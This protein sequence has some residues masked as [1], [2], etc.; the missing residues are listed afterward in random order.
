MKLNH[1]KSWFCWYAT[2]SPCLKKLGVHELSR[3]I[4]LTTTIIL[5]L[6][7]CQANGNAANRLMYE[8]FDDQVLD[9]RFNIIGHDWAILNPPQYNMN[10]VG[11]SGSGYCFTSGTINEAYLHWRNQIPNPWPTDEFYVSFW[12]RYPTFRTTDSHENLKLFYPHWDGAESYVH[13]AMSNTNSIY[14]SA[15]AKGTMVTAGRWLNCPN[16]AD[17]KWHHYEF[18]VKFSTGV[19]KFWYDGALIVNDAYGSGRW[20]PTMR[21]ISAPSIDAEEP[22]SFSRQVDDWEVWD[23]MPSGG[24]PTPGPPTPS[25]PPTDTTAPSYSGFSP[26]SGATAVPVSTNIT[27]HVKDSGSGVDKS[28]IAM[29]VNGSKVTPIITGTP[30]DYILFFNPPVNFGYGTK[31]LVTLSAKDMSGNSTGIQNFSFTTSTSNL[32]A[33]VPPSPAGVFIRIM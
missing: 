16:Q 26:A 25:N 7:I 14:Y 18:F 30:A 9:S 22:G 21:Y 8:N 15:K 6:L 23:G 28:S 19:S 13:Y 33:V 11:R 10:A 31:V 29:T 1:V 20:S 12:M 4:Q 27:I 24:I 2:C 32:N 3:I 17:G 5:V